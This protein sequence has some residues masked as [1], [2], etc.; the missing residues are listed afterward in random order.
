MRRKQGTLIESEIALLLAAVALKRRGTVRFHGYLIARELQEATGARRL[1]SHGT[2]YKT[3]ARLEDAGLLESEW[4]TPEPTARE[5]RPRRRQYTVTMDGEG[6][7]A[8]ALAPQPQSSRAVFA[9]A[10]AI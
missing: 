1:L 6:A 8:T 9:R 5:T 10:V 2:L 3:L 4:E 7:L